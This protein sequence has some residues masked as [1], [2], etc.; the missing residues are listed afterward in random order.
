[1]FLEKYDNN[2]FPR[3]HDFFF[4]VNEKMN[5]SKPCT[6]LYLKNVIKIKNPTDRKKY[7]AVFKKGGQCITQKFGH[8]DYEDYTI[9]KDKKRRDLY[10]LRHQKDLR[11]KDPTRAGYLSMFLLWNKKTL[12]QSQ[13][14]YCKRLI[15]YNKTGHFNTTI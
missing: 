15:Q 2:W 1:M 8:K 6:K 13:R 10:I 5:T 11:T 9:H 7:I 4:V 3:K 14:D 12:K